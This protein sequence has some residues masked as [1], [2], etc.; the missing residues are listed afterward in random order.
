M[1]CATFASVPLEGVPPSGRQSRVIPGALLTLAGSMACTWAMAQTPSTAALPGDVPA[2]ASA[3]NAPATQPLRVRGF[4]VTG[5]NPLSFEEQS[6]VLAPYLRQEPTLDMLQQ[7]TAALEARLQQKGF[8]LHRVVLP[9]QALTET[10]ALQIVTFAIGQVSVEGAQA[11]GE[12]NI[13]RSLPELQEGT[14]PHLNRLAVQTAVAN[15]NPSKQT[16]VVLKASD[17]QPDRIDVTLRVKDTSPA[18]FSV[19]LANTGSASSGRDR[20]TFVASHANLFDRD[21]QIMAA[22]TTSMA[23]PGD[24]SQLG[25]TYRVPLYTAGSMV[26]VS[27]TRSTVVGQFGT[28][29]VTGAGHTL[30]TSLTHHYGTQDGL[31]R[32]A[33]VGVDDKVFDPVALSG[34]A[35]RRSRPLSLGFKLRQQADTAYWDAGATVATNVGGGQGNSLAAYQSERP[36]VSSRQWSALRLQVSRVDAWSSGWLLALRGQAQWASTALMS[37]EQFG[38]GGVG[39]L[40]GTGERVLAGDSG[41]SASLEITTPEWSPGWRALAFADAGWLRQKGAAVVPSDRAASAGVGL[42]YA[43][44]AFNVA[45]D[46]G[47]IVTGSRALATTAPRS[48][49]YKWHLNVSARF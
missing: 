25:L 7:A 26:D 18:H 15:E 23:R 48:G 21:H 32:W 27:Y 29:S 20:L 9:P 36:A 14:T 34:S 6:L 16:Q 8:A 19:N 3:A 22:Y 35:K 4:S 41:V 11:F 37:G 2:A 49:D 5:D 30:G 40:R 47:R 1:M 13:R 17:D 10:I 28:F 24:V 38:L 44:G 12:D 46:Y 42:R 33:V 31:S 39:S 45:L 43:V